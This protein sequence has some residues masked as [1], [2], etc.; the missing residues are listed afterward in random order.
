VIIATPRL[1]EKKI[2]CERKSC[3]WLMNIKDIQALPDSLQ[4]AIKL[5]PF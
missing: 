4:M 3:L 1:V 2:C 5:L